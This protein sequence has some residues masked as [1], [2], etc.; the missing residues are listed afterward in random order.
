MGKAIVLTTGANSGIGL[1]TAIEV[2]RRGYRSV[3]SVRSDEK[4][5]KLLEAAAAA[6]V[7]I[8]PVILDVTDA[9]ACSAVMDDLELYGLVN[10]AGYTNTGAIEDVDDDDV[11]HQFVTMTVAP[12]RLAKLALPAMRENGRGR[13]VN[14]SSIYGRTTT[15]LT[16]WYQATKHALEAAS[17]ALRVE[18]ASEGVQ[19]VL[20]EPGGFKTGIWAD[21]NTA[22][23]RH[24]GSRYASA[25]QREMQLTKG[26]EPFMGDPARVAA[27]IGRALDS[28]NPRA[29]YVVGL[30]AHAIVL[31][32]R[33]TPTMIKDLVNRFGFGL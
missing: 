1:S 24:A 25:Y 5:E 9:E 26:L 2:A 30:D 19:V 29:R 33:F 8:E 15:P 3:G 28:T 17:D 22:L 31:A 21:N 23:A 4:A 18:L 27:V 16:G 10:N 14:V 32:D 20:V 6:D 12:M 13:I 11:R 7:E